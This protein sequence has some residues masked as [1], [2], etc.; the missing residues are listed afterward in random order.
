MTTEQ[1]RALFAWPEHKRQVE[2]RPAG[3]ARPERGVVTAVTEQYVF[4]RYAGQPA[5]KA[6]RAAD[7]HL[8]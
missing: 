6:T 1:A 7:L 2:Y 8:V 3:I 4:V 5:A